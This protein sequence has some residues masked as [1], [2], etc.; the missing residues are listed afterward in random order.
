MDG[1]EVE[2]GCLENSRR[3]NVRG[4]ESLS[5]RHFERAYKASGTLYSRAV[6]QI[7]VSVIVAMI[8]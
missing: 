7:V 5:I 6:L 2:G 1:R 4:F 8:C 3:E